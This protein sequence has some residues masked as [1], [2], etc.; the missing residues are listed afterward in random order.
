MEVLFYGIAPI[1]TDE[2]FCIVATVWPSE[3]KKFIFNW[4]AGVQAQLTKPN[5]HCPA[6]VSTR[7]PGVSRLCFS[8]LLSLHS[9]VYLIVSFTS[10]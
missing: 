4:T 1:K 9:S 2:G 5:K 10:M 6:E 8:S 7:N 3:G